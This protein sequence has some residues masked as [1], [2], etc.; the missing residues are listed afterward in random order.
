MVSAELRGR[1]KFRTITYPKPVSAYDPGS[2]IAENARKPGITIKYGIDA[3]SE[4]ADGHYLLQE[5]FRRAL[6]AAPDPNESVATAGFAASRAMS[7]SS[8]PITAR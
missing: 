7:S 6:L 8:A 3:A 4:S 5:L 1:F 2:A